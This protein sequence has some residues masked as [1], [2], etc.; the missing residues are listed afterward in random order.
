[1][2]PH[3]SI[4]AW[5]VPW[6]EEPGG[7]QSTGQQ[8]RTCLATNAFTF[9]FVRVSVYVNSSLPIHPTPP[10]PLGIQ[11]FILCICVSVSALQISS[12]VPFL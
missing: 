8:S 5:R 12:S 11:K 3:S 10:L 1:M 9:H 4:F 7:P 6:T 2:A